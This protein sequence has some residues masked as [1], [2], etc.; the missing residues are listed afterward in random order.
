MTKQGR[1]GS[2]DEDLNQALAILISNTRSTKRPLPLTEVARWLKVAIDKLGSFS[3]VAERL[4]LSEKMLRQFSY[5]NRLTPSALELVAT[6]T[7]DSV[8]A[9][10]HLGMLPRKQQQAVVGALKSGTIETRDIR[11]I[12][13]LHRSNYSKSINEIIDR[14]KR[15]KT[16]REYI[17][18]FVVRGSRDRESIINALQKNISAKE[19]IRVELDG[20]LGRLVL[21]AAG[22][23]QL[24]KAARKLGTSMSQVI[25]TILEG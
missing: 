13:Q 3:A 19:I 15:E 7:L 1:A 20:A 5:V 2:D 24:M 4:G 10:T 23:K 8:D 11:P 6:R 12:V 14:V 9:V 25:P 22:K 18:E 17:A 16:T 21:T